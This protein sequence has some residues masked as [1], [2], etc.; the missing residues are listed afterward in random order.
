[1]KQYADRKENLVHQK[2]ETVNDILYDNLLKALVYEKVL[3][4]NCKKSI[5]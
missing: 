5:H 4:E 3:K 1:M 2:I